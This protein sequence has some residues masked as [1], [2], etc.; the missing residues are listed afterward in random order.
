M[1]CRMTRIW[2][3]AMSLYHDLSLWPV[4]VNVTRH[5]EAVPSNVRPPSPQDHRHVADLGNVVADE[6]GVANF[7]L[8][9]K[10]Q[11]LYDGS[12]TRARQRLISST[13][14]QP[15]TVRILKISFWNLHI[16]LIEC[17][18][19]TVFIECILIDIYTGPMCDGFNLI[20]HF[21]QSP[22][23]FATHE[24]TLSLTRYLPAPLPSARTRLLAVRS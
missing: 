3:I 12:V 19:G 22:C 6:T 1:L 9:D 21:Q 10:L 11:T 24:L 15:I 20:A 8:Q 18:L 23:L 2:P 13:Y 17:L 16:E 7:Q 4:T 14:S 5:A